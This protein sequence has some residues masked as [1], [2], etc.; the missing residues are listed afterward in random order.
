MPIVVHYIADTNVLLQ[1][2][3]NYIV[4]NYFFI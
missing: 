4:R 3:S 1:S 2:Y